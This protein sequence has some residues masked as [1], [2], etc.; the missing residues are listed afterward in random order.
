M[1]S[2]AFVAN[3]FAAI[4]VLLPACLLTTCGGGGGS[5]KVQYL[6]TNSYVTAVGDLNGDSAADVVVVRVHSNHQD[7]TTVA[8]RLQDPL[9]PGTFL[10][11]E[12]HI[13]SG[14]MHDSSIFV[15]IGD[16]N[17]DGLPDLVT[18]NPDEKAVSVLFQDPTN[19][20]TFLAAVSL[21]VGSHAN[22]VAIGDLN[23]DGLLDLAV[24]GGDLS[25]L[26]QDT[27]RPGTFL[28]TISLGVYSSGVAIGDLNGDGSV[29]LASV[30][31]TVKIFLQEAGQPSGFLPPRDFPAGGDAS[32]IGIEDLND[33]DLLD[34]AVLNDRKDGGVSILL[35]DSSSPASFLPPS[36]Y[37]TEDWPCSIAIGDLNN[38]GRL[39]LAVASSLVYVE[40]AHESRGFVSVLL[41]D[42][43]TPG[44]FL[45]RKDYS[46]ATYL[47]TVAVGDLNEDGFYDLAIG[48]SSGG[49]LWF[50]DPSNPG[51]FLSQTRIY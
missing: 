33:D 29:D 6:E 30:H 39:D 31:D 25:I 14:A 36:S 51:T 5:D 49:D 41:Q 16:L 35:Q 10:P 18:T 17:N 19:R 28:P 44:E 48:S 32:S 12:E 1:K 23:G 22:G 7:V 11:A 37:R 46:G 8:I 47:N 38:D 40:S 15:T 27:V 13:V 9:R 24:S 50:Q 4:G 2:I 42:P 26:L 20:G 45:P 34:L 43:A 21:P 3:A